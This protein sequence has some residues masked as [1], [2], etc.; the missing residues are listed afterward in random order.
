MFHGVFEL[1]WWSCLWVTLALTHV[2]IVSVTIF[3]HRH[4]AHRALEL[5]AIPSHFFRLWL[6][7]TTGMGTKEWASIHRKHHAKCETSEDPH[8]PQV[9]GINKVLWTGVMLYVKEAR[10]PETLARYGHGTPD[11]WMERHVYVPYQKGGVVI[12]LA[13]D[14]ALFGPVG[15]L[16]W[17][18]QVGWIPF[19]AAGVIN[20]LGHFRGYRNFACLDAST[21]I[22]PW[23]IF[24][25]GEELHN[26]HHA[27]ATSAKLSN[28]W[29]ELDIGWGYI[30]LLEMLGLA[31]V[32]KVAPRPKLAELRPAVD[33]QTL[34]AVITH[35]YDLMARYMKSLQQIAR[36]EVGKI[37]STRAGFLDSRRF[38]ALVA[39]DSANLASRDRQDLETVLQQSSRLSTVYAMRDELATVW[40]RSS[41]TREQLLVQLQV[42]CRRA[43]ESG[44]AQLEELSLRLR[45]YAVA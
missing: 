4:Q 36:E 10:K 43:E 45:R 23:G 5:H 35:R 32:K 15:A 41:A 44:I 18:V 29:Y 6:W 38:Q 7:L 3:L 34:Q 13:V 22:F 1:S 21:N 14:L 17:L 19:W 42:W 28:K 9:L 25:G 20:G 40:G 2:T 26:N 39:Q 24:I 33:L 8:S 11:D 27:F 31:R 16:M 30:R 12:M 37:K